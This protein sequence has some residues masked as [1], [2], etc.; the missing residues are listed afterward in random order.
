MKGNG[1]FGMEAQS[2]SGYEGYGLA[3]SFQ[4]SVFAFNQTDAN[5]IAAGG[6]DSGLFLSTDGGKSW[7][8]LDDPTGEGLTDSANNTIPRLSRPRFVQ[9]DGPNTLYV[10]SQG[11]GLWKID[12]NFDLAPD[13]NEPNNLLGNATALEKTTLQTLKDRT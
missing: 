10:G 5:I 12:Y 6:I 7:R 4:P 2:S 1:A 9:F 11:R 13:S 8:L 3:R